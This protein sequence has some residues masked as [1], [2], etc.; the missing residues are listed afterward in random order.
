MFQY[1]E[2]LKV[3]KRQEGEMRIIFDNPTSG[4]K[5]VII[6]WNRSHVIIGLK[7]VGH[8]SEEIRSYHLACVE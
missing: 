1:Q 7:E 3:E 6:F 5:G 2:R 4:Q 8:F